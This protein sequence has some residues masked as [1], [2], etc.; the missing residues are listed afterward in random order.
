MGFARKKDWNYCKGGQ[1]HGK[2]N[3]GIRRGLCQSGYQNLLKVS[4]TGRRKHQDVLAHLDL[5]AAVV[6]DVPGTRKPL[7]G[8]LPPR[9]R[10]LNR[11]AR[12]Y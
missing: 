8:D 9:A 2:H 4:Q 1:D 12:I 3:S 5:I 6:Q 10:R 7:R 11:P